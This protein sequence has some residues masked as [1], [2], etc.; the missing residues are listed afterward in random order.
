MILN[1]L[2]WE[3]HGVYWKYCGKISGQE[4]IDSTI[5]IY[6]D[7]RFDDLKYKLIDFLDAEIIEISNDELTLLAYQH[8]AAEKS[9]PNIKNAIVVR[10]EFDELAKKF[11]AF[12]DDSSWLA[13]V[14]HD[15]EEANNWLARESTTE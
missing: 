15:R 4:I 10:P 13:Q 12:F 11:V 7:S 5:V 1:K 6:G 3:Q 14:F 2:T 9:N 8:K